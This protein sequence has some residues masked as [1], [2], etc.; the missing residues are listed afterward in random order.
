MREELT[1]AMH[2]LGFALDDLREANSPFG[3]HWRGLRI[4][5]E[6]RV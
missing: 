3:T 6:H 4:S 1:K 5:N 2:D